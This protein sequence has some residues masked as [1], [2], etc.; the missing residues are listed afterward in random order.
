[1]CHWVARML[2]TKVRLWIHNTATNTSKEHTLE[3]LS[4]VGMTVIHKGTD[5]TLVITD[6]NKK[7]HFVTFNQNTLDIT[8][9]T[10]KDITFTPRHISIHPVT[11]QLVIADDTNKA[12][13]TCDTQGNIQNS[14]KV[15]TDVGKNHECGVQ[16]ALMMALSYLTALNSAGRVHW[17]DSQGRVTHTYGQRDGEG[18]NVTHMHMVRGSQGQLVVADTDNHRLHLVDASGHL[19]CYLLT[20]S[21][22]IQY[23]RCVWLDETASLLYV[24][25]RPRGNGRYRCTL[26]HHHYLEPSPPTPN[27]HCKSNC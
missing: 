27:T 1:M 17:V 6:R 9:H 7:L 21:D 24:A 22:G 19:S 20:Q 3:G 11:G 4:N 8:T 18:L 13:V 14:I 23:P 2:S 5:N 12:I 10:V 26:H 16:W 25:H 15:Q